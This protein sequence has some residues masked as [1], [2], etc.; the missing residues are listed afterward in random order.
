MCNCWIDHT[1]QGC[2]LERIEL[3]CLCLLHLC[4][5]CTCPSTV[6]HLWEVYLI[7]SPT[8][9]FF[10][11]QE[12]EHNLDMCRSRRLPSAKAL[13]FFKIFLLALVG[14]VSML[15]GCK[16]VEYSNPTLASAISTLTPAFTFTLAV[17]FRFHLLLFRFSL[18]KVI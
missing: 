2:V 15:S 16:G 14:F 11:S 3:L 4:C 17:I 10:H 18:G 8:L 1:V 7:S 6:P 9:S 5:C 12:C 13:F